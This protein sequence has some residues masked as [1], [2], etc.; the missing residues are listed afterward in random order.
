MGADPAPEAIGG[1]EW[2]ATVRL[3]ARFAAGYDGVSGIRLYRL[4]VSIDQ[5]SLWGAHD[6]IE[7]L[8]LGHRY[9]VSPGSLHPSGTY[10]R[11]YYPTN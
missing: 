2:P 5:A 7:I 8:R 9:A 1:Q 11:L 6:G 3:S 10:Y 4:P